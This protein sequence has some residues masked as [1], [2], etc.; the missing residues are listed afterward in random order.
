MFN[1]KLVDIGGDG[2]VTEIETDYETLIETEISVQEVINRHLGITT[3]RL[4]H[5]DDLVYDVKVNGHTAGI[6]VMRT[7]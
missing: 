3:A 6:V 4:V 1:I 5:V 2:L 7:L